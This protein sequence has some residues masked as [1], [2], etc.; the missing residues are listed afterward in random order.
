[1]KVDVKTSL[2]SSG[3]G[4]GTHD[5]DWKCFCSCIIIESSKTG[6]VVQR[7]VVA[8][9]VVVDYGKRG[10]IMVGIYSEG[11]QETVLLN[12]TNTV[13]ERS[14]ERLLLSGIGRLLASCGTRGVSVGLS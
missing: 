6:L 4:F 14:F 8:V 10:A 5:D 3:S 11:C 1:M 2:G 7:G 13:A 12:A 9:A